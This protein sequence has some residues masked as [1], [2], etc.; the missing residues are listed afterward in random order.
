[1]K[2]MLLLGLLVLSAQI[3]LVRAQEA[4]APPLRA[5]GDPR[6]SPRAAGDGR[7]RPAVRRL[8][9]DPARPVAARARRATPRARSRRRPSQRR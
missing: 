4:A 7:G 6:R 1:M 8:R 2:N 9:A 5:R 3:L